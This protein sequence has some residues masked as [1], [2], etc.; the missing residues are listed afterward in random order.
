[1][2][3]CL[4]DAEQGLQEERTKNAKDAWYK[5]EEKP[6]ETTTILEY[7]DGPEVVYRIDEWVEKT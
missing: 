1:M 2:H 5:E 6:M 4:E 3:T 7:G